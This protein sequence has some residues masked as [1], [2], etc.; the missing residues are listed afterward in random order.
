MNSY[1]NEM[2]SLMNIKVMTLPAESPWCNGIVERH[3]GIL[4]Q[5]IEAV[6]DDTGCNIDI[7]I[8]WSVNAKKH[9]LV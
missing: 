5:M 8:A 7:A 6:V 2:C 3:N 1:F 4:G 9:Q